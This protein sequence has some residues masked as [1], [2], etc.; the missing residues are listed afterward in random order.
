MK[1]FPRYNT[2]KKVNI[3]LIVWDEKTKHK[4][5]NKNPC[6][7][8]FVS[9]AVEYLQMDIAFWGWL[10]GSRGETVPCLS[11]SFAILFLKNVIRLLV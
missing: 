9:I 3:L 11:K 2:E 8:V 10:E 1:G 6:I 7:Y 5:T 4:Q